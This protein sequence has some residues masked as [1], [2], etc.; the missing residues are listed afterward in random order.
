MLIGCLEK[1]HTKV[2]KG[3]R[4]EDICT[5]QKEVKPYREKEKWFSKL[6]RWLVWRCRWRWWNK[7]SPICEK[8]MI[9]GQGLYVHVPGWLRAGGRSCLGKTVCR[10]L[11]GYQHGQPGSACVDI[12]LWVNLHVYG[13]F[14]GQ[15]PK[16][17]NH[18]H[19][20]CPKG[21]FF[22]L[23]QASAWVRHVCPLNICESTYCARIISCFSNNVNPLSL[24]LGFELISFHIYFYLNGGKGRCLRLYIMRARNSAPRWPLS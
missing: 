24:S 18:F 16:V 21:Q 1:C 2:A 6:A 12:E 10:K 14:F 11:A 15:F 20:F 17:H 22:I 5:W 3:Q 8:I 4:G 9:D 7:W 13:W 19:F 23:Y